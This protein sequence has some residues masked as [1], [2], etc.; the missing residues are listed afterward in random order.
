MLKEIMHILMIL[1]F[2]GSIFSIIHEIIKNYKSDKPKAKLYFYLL[3]FVI[4][5]TYDLINNWY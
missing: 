4:Y 1:L 3:V 2:V 5:F